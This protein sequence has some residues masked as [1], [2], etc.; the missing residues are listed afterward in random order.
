VLI[1][2]DQNYLRGTGGAGTASDAATS[3]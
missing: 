2:A 1:A 3:L